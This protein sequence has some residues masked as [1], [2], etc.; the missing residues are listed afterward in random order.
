MSKIKITVDSTCD[1]GAELM[2]KYNMDFCPL[3][4][5]L[6]EK[7][8]K[9]TIEINPD[10]IY[11]FVDENKILP[12]TSAGTITDYTNFFS[13]Y[14]NEGYEVI[15]ICISSTMSCS[16]QNASIAAEE[17]GNCYVIDSQNLSTASGH[18]A[19]MAAELAAEG[20]EAEEIVKILKETVP[21]VRGSFIVSIMDYLKMG[22]RCSAMAAF[23]ANMLR[24]MPCIEV[25]DGVLHPTK[26]YRGLF[27]AVLKNYVSDQLADLSKIEPKR[28]FITHSG[29]DEKIV[30]GIYDQV[31]ALDYFEN[32]EITRAGCVIT[33]HCGPGTLGIL[34]INK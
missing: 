22:G 9:D 12:K 24:I 33:S 3:Y 1:L 31:K 5:T 29:C 21:K 25:D 15:H 30:Q 17:V 6:G 23:G 14:V 27:A 2:Q 10:D 18:L 19:I 20:K 7:S 4:V 13:K 16:Y 11:K 34:F 28:I 32:I 26:K 8:L